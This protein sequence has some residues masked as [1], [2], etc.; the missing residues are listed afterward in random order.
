MRFSASTLIVFFLATPVWA[1]D[2]PGWFDRLFVATEQ[3]ESDEEQ[4]SF[5][6]RLLEDNLSGEG[7]IVEIT[8]FE[9]AL[10]GKA[11]LESLTVADSNGIWLTIS[12]A[13]LD[14]NRSA[15]LRGEVSV[16]ELS[17]KTIQFDRLPLPAEAELPSAEAQGFRLP[18]LPVSVEIDD[19]S[20]EQ[21]RI[22]APVYGVETLASLAG[23]LD[24]ADG[25]GSASVAIDRL[26]GE[27]AISLEAGFSNADGFTVTLCTWSSSP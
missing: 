14:W 22:G 21:I 2:A 18:E 20:A 19:V 10:G 11:T 23:S 8:G 16:N 7:R 13:V 1:Q 5:V 4:G 27:G 12:D 25:N 15:L 17:A 9:G 24:L 26:D 3:T 6:E